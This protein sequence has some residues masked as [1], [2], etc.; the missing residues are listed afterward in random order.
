MY[1]EGGEKVPCQNEE[2]EPRDSSDQ[3]LW[4]RRLSPFLK[5]MQKGE[6]RPHVR[7]RKGSQGTVVI[8][9][10]G[11]A[12]CL[13]SL[14]VCRRGR[15]GPSQNEEGEPRDSSDLVLCFRRLSPFLKPVQKEFSMI[16]L[17]SGHLL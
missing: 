11:S 8:K 13:L 14:S 1:A 5:C 3:V 12:G 10:Y 7:T 17:W 15:T 16:C 6:K 9:Y 4:F 2:G